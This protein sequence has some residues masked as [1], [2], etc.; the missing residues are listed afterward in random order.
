MRS[1]KI[2]YLLLF[3]AVWLFII[4]PAVAFSQIE[5]FPL[6][7]KSYK[8]E[9][10]EYILFVDPTSP[11]GAGEA[12]VRFSRKGI[13]Q[14]EKRIDFTFQEAIITKNGV[15]AGYSYSYGTMGAAPPGIKPPPSDTRI[16]MMNPDG[17]ILL[18]DATPRGALPSAGARLPP[19]ARPSGA[20]PFVLGMYLDEYT[21]I[22]VVS[23]QTASREEKWR[24]F[25][26]VSGAAEGEINPWKAIGSPGDWGPICME[27]AQVAGTPFMIAIFPSESAPGKANK[28]IRAA[29]IGLDGKVAWQRDLGDELEHLPGYDRSGYYKK[30]NWI[31]SIDPPALFTIRS[32]TEKLQYT[33]QARLNAE[34]EWKFFDIKELPDGGAPAAA[35]SGDRDRYTGKISQFPEI[36]LDKLPSINL[37][38]TVGPAIGS[39]QKIVAHHGGFA[40]LCSSASGP[41]DLVL[42]NS[43]GGQILTI[44]LSD[45]TATYRHRYHLFQSGPG[46]FVTSFASNDRLALQQVDVNTKEV[47]VVATLDLDINSYVCAL[48]GGESVFISNGKATF[49]SADFTIKKIVK[50]PFV[51]SPGGAVV[52]TDGSI[53]ILDRDDNTIYVI[54]RDGEKVATITL[55]TITKSPKGLIQI[56]PSAEGRVAVVVHGE[57]QVYDLNIQG[58][59]VKSQI[60]REINGREIGARIQGMSI[61]P[62]GGFF[63]T[64]GEHIF[65]IRADGLVTR[66]GREHFGSKIS[67]SG[68]IS[69][70]RANKKV[71]LISDQEA[72]VQV[73]DDA[74]KR[75]FTCAPGPLEVPDSSFVFPVPAIVDAQG[76]IYFCITKYRSVAAEWLMYNSNGEFA[77]VKTLRMTALPLTVR[78]NLLAGRHSVFY[79]KGILQ[80]GD[81]KGVVLTDVN[82][83]PTGQWLD[84]SKF[85]GFCS[86]GAVGFL[87]KARRLS[88]QPMYQYA[89]CTYDANGVARESVIY[90]ESESTGA[91]VSVD[92]HCIAVSVDSKI[93]LSTR[94]GEPIGYINISPSVRPDQEAAVFLM[95]DGKELWVS[96]R[97]VRPGEFMR[98]SLENIQK[99]GK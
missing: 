41:P 4:S 73:F 87:L 44:P 26:L 65:S 24:S 53:A 19:T 21:N 38:A 10:G 69:I 5:P 93:Y 56:A 75:L 71:Y 66:L 28:N 83:L 78:W 49:L 98:Y 46:I 15:I 68:N 40:A 82:R 80:F 39:I 54:R 33:I 55:S 45:S 86:D 52:L 32:Y 72:T 74:G 30:P 89:V 43:T 51:K 63:V 85:G 16:V 12:N 50:L 84:Q 23:V 91:E 11:D 60:L 34:N 77:G 22:F 47:R 31:V 48:G 14:W 2:L 36:R 96:E 3:A 20:L 88:S 79:G 70:V 57:S 7:P 42:L 97:F 90:P 6:H 1:S 27:R 61:A 62:G 25:S 18:N 95:N 29:A 81:D 35:A 13:V 99:A 67:Y 9:S 94:G 58:S 8:S 76:N 64:D 17:S 92:D 37:E 59:V